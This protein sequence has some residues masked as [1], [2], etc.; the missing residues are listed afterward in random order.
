MV[1]ER[2]ANLRFF[3]S[4]NNRSWLR[5]FTCRNC[6]FGMPSLALSLARISLNRGTQRRF[7]SNAARLAEI[8][9]LCR[10]SATSSAK[11]NQ[12]W[13]LFDVRTQFC[14]PKTKPQTKSNYQR[15]R[16]EFS[17]RLLTATKLLDE[18]HCSLHKRV[19]CCATGN[20]ATAQRATL[21][22]LRNKAG[23]AGRDATR[24]AKQ[25]AHKQRTKSEKSILATK[26]K[27]SKAEKS[28]HKFALKPQKWLLS[29]SFCTQIAAHF[30]IRRATKQSKAELL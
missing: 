4:A 29:V 6:A 15:T 24:Q 9:T 10:K 22:L 26:V 12:F 7:Y 18:K 30:C 5:L 23:F 16:N 20:Y 25:K 2:N 28:L 19:N 27:L 11:F 21:A 1:A 3:R 13:K 17:R 8:E 14:S